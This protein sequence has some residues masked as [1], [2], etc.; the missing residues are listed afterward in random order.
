MYDRYIHSG[1][2]DLLI[3]AQ[4]SSVFMEINHPIRKELLRNHGRQIFIYGLKPWYKSK[5]DIA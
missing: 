3:I 1:R 2:L 4:G 5:T